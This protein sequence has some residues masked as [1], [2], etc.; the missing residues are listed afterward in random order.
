MAQAGL[1]ST[2]SYTIAWKRTASDTK[3]D[4]VE[5]KSLPSGLHALA[6]DLVYFTH[7]GYAG[8]SAFARGE[9][10]EAERNANFVAVGILVRRE[11][12]SGRL[13][14]GWLLAGR[15]EK[16]A[17]ALAQ[18]DT[19][20][21]LEEFW[22]DQTS[23][24]TATAKHAGGK[25][26]SRDRAI[27]SVTAVPKNEE[28]L[29]AYHPALAM[30]QYLDLFGPLV[31]RLQQAALLRKRILFV[32][33]P[34]V[35]TTCEFGASLLAGSTSSSG[36]GHSHSHSHSHTHTHT[37]THSNADTRSLQ[38]LRPLEHLPARRRA[39]CARHRRPAPPAVA[40]LHRRARHP[41]PRGAAPAQG[42]PHAGHRRRRGLGRLHHRRDHRDQAAAVRHCRRDAAP[43]RREDAAPPLAEAAHE[44]GR[45]HQGQPARRRPLPP[46]APRA[47][48]APPA[49]HRDL[50][51]RRAAQRRRRAPHLSRLNR[52]QARRRR[53]QRRLRRHGRGARH[54]VAAGLPRLHVV[55][56]RRR[57]R[58]IHSSRA[59]A[60]PRARR[61]HIR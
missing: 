35:R 25:G 44:R 4:G 9:A 36:H 39:P 15:L 20:A 41:L 24:A 19:T 56:Q 5:Y 27:S 11:G 33:S 14:R 12:W 60:G 38:P 13:G 54:L 46:A 31:F 61:R 37:H 29:P 8:L 59:R 51:R 6:S 21:P 28:R 43:H 22:A 7:E 57:A 23:S 30:G 55:G 47:V 58:R 45:R 18:D 49:S 16:L 26:S 52:R 40:L 42:R 3:L 48:E 10:S 53:L 50:P 2:Y 32:G 1:T 34:P 17:A